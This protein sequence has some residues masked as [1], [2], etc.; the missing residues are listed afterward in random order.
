MK[1]KALAVLLTIALIVCMAPMALAAILL[2]EDGTSV[3]GYYSFEIKDG[4]KFVVNAQPGID[5]GNLTQ[6]DTTT[7]NVA[8]IPYD[9]VQNNLDETDFAGKGDGDWS[10]ASWWLPGW[11]IPTAGPTT[12]EFQITSLS[13]NTKYFVI[14]ANGEEAPNYASASF[15]TDATGKGLKK[16]PSAAATITTHPT[17]G[18]VE[19]KTNKTMSVAATGATLS[20][21]WQWSASENGTYANITNGGV[22]SGATTDTLTITGYT[23]GNALWYRCVVTNTEAGKAPTPTNSNA[24]QLTTKKIAQTPT[25]TV[26]TGED[27]RYGVT[28]KKATGTRFVTTPATT[29]AITYTSG[30]TSVATINSTTGA[31][32]YLKPGTTT[33]TMNVAADANYNAG[34]ATATLTVGKGKLTAPAGLAFS[35]KTGATYADVVCNKQ[36]ANFGGSSVAGTYTLTGVNAGDTVAAGNVNWKFTPAANAEYYEELTGATALTMTAK[37]P[38]TAS[39]TKDG[40]AVTKL[41]VPYGTADFTLGATATA[42][43]ANATWASG[44]TATATI[45]AT[46]KVS[47]VAA[48]TTTITL[49]VP[50]NDD[51][52]AATATLELTVEKAKLDSVDGFTTVDASGKTLADV[53]VGAIGHVGGKEITGTIAWTNGATDATDVEKNKA[54]T[55]TFTPDD[56]NYAPFDGSVTPWKAST[57]G[58]IGGGS[59]SSGSTYYDVSYEV[60]KKGE[61][62]GKGT[63]SVKANAYPNKVPTVTA[64]EGYEFKGWSVDGKT[65]VDPTDVRI[66]KD[67]T[68]TAIFES[69]KQ[70][71]LNSEDHI[72]YIRGYEDGTFAPNKSITR[73]EAITIFARLMN[74]KMDVSETYTASFSDVK[75]GAWY[76]NYIGYMEDYNIING[77]EDGTFRPDAAITRAEFAAMASRFDKLE[78]TDKNAFSDVGSSHWAIESINSAYAKGWIGGYPDGTFRPNQNISRAEVVSIVNSMLARKID[79]SS[80]A[81]ATY[82]TFPDVA[83]NHWAYYDVIEASNEHDYDKDDAG[84]NTWK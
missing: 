48:G 80:I 63:E 56:A 15:E 74:E 18:Q 10:N 4:I 11:T 39:I 83:S 16:D 29:G 67:T 73:A 55:Y 5:A 72:V 7:I 28:G 8:V 70:A 53:K 38:N 21:Q 33:I 35:V 40:Q 79:A 31:L 49:T 12:H 57:G 36:A 58:S 76:A 82:K 75:A 50:E 19:V 24:A 54:Y 69:T 43:A 45:D 68:F 77:Y 22:F 2:P 37:D 78:S 32:T 44:T 47:I 41:T 60:G 52:E 1:K 84:K 9:H 59:S 61:I 23:D 51:Y 34:S 26:P 81:D 25:L 66:T 17:G 27:A 6:D 65:I 64:K 3:A 71:T 42:N 13:A 14:V 46:G 30:D 20:Y 62:S